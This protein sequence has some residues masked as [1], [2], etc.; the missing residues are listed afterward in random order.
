MTNQPQTAMAD[1]E[2]T[3]HP[4][5]LPAGSVRAVLALTITGLFWILLL[6][7]EEKNIP[8]PLFL[9]FCTAMVLLFFFAHGKSISHQEG[10]SPPW[11]LPRGTIRFVIIGGT[12]AVFGFY[13]YLHKEL[14][15]SKLVPQP[16][17]L[18]QWPKLLIGFAIGL[19]SGY[20]IGRGPWRKSDAFQDIQAWVSLIAMLG[21]AVEVIIILFINPNLKQEMKI[22]L[23]TWEA[24]LTGIVAWY[25]GART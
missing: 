22:D 25:F 1:Q 16:A 3:R 5:G 7:P 17:Q 12:I 6:I 8:V 9:Y 15:L 13:Y 11:G 14:P 19:G 18:V 20:L 4:L 23:S 2:L 24:I 10:R 21:L